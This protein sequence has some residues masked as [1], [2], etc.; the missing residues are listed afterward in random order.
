MPIRV[1]PIIEL[2]SFAHEINITSVLIHLSL[3]CSVFSIADTVPSGDFITSRCKLMI[4][5]LY[6]SISA[7]ILLQ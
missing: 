4:L 3:F 2:T 5:M 1:Q 6:F 7:N